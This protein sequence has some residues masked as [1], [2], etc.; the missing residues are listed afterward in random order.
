MSASALM[1]RLTHQSRNMTTALTISS[2][3]SVE[4]VRGC[5]SCSFISSFGFNI[6]PDAHF[7]KA[8]TCSTN[9]GG[10]DFRYLSNRCLS[11]YEVQ[12]GESC[13]CTNRLPSSN[14]PER[15]NLDLVRPRLPSFGNAS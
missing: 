15:M 6:P 8:A 10:V 14:K 3:Q 1:L 5:D 13:S 12:S 4:L 2:M 7:S 9:I 11:K